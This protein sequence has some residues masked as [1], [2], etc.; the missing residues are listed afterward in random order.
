MKKMRLYLGLLAIA[1]TVSV[2]IVLVVRPSF[3]RGLSQS[4]PDRDVQT[5]RYGSKREQ[6]LAQVNLRERHDPTTLEPLIAILHEPQSSPEAQAGAIPVVGDFAV[7]GNAFA[8]EALFTAACDLTVHPGIRGTARHWL[9]LARGEAL[10]F[11]AKQFF[12]ADEAKQVVSLLVLLDIGSP[13]AAESILRELAD[14]TDQESFDSAGTFL[15][16]LGDAAIPAL[17]ETAQSGPLHIRDWAS[18]QLGLM[19]TMKSFERDY[20]N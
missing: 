9:V 7:E 17:R 4:E 18:T 20:R 6:V 13:A 11:V 5:L 3:R 12:E 2:C 8:I 1:V 16:S 14:R 19:E 10:P 15:T